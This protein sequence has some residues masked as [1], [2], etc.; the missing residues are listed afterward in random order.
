MASRKMA[1]AGAFVAAGVL[2]CSANAQTPLPNIN[3]GY[4]ETTDALTDSVRREMCS[5]R[6]WVKVCIEFAP[7]G[8]IMRTES[9]DYFVSSVGPALRVDDNPAFKSDPHAVKVSTTR[10]F[11]VAQKRPEDGIWDA[12][13][14]SLV[15]QMV[16]GK[17]MLVRIYT[18]DAGYT[19]SY[20]VLDHLCRQLNF[21]LPTDD[22]LRCDP[23]KAY[24]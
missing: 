10:H 15:G 12:D 9:H 18:V 13:P 2:T 1:I 8:L 24:N 20:I 4:V 6:S 5:T 7:E 21:I 16:S 23:A 19:D 22:S 3:W 14:M 17:L 11:W